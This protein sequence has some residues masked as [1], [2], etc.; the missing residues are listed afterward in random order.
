MSR[1]VLVTGATGY[2]GG[3]L[4][5]P[6][7]S[8]GLPRPLPGPPARAGAGTAC[9]GEVEIAGGDLLESASVARAL[10]GVDTAFY[11]VHALELGRRPLARR[12]RRR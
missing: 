8:R 1:L 4:V 6:L 10:E 11:L 5:P 9:P 2:V 3:R 7:L 12:N